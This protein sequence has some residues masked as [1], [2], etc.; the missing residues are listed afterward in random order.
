[1][2]GQK[3]V[4]YGMPSSSLVI[5]LEVP[6]ART[7]LQACTVIAPALS[8][9][10]TTHLPARARARSSASINTAMMPTILG[11]VRPA[12]ALHRL[13]SHKARKTQLLCV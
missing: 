10:R 9:L 13:P 11:R 4:T 8:V 6:L 1:M 5:Y 7:V 12:Q 3:Q 2:P